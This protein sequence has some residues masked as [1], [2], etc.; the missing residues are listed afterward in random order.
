MKITIKIDIHGK[1]GSYGC[2]TVIN[3]GGVRITTVPWTQVSQTD[4]KC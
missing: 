1:S 4:E 3:H 2:H